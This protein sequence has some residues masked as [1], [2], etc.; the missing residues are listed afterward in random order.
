M[1]R[2]RHHEHA[3]RYPEALRE[4]I[5]TK[6]ILRE[7]AGYPNFVVWRYSEVSGQRKKPPFNP[8]THEAASPSDPRSWGALETALTAVASGTHQGIGFMLSQNPFTGIDLDHSIEE[9]TLLPWARDIV[10]A[11]DTYTEYSPSWNRATGTDGVHLLECAQKTPEP[12][13]ETITLATFAS[14]NQAAFC[15][16]YPCYERQSHLW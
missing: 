3:A 16:Y 1:S 12:A 7:L 13:D 9:G 4:R 5:E 14:C 10:E 2:E 6:G 11:L 8:K 15:L